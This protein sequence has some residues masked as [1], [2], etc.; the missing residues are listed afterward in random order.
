MHKS[1]IFYLLGVFSCLCICVRNMYLCKI[2]LLY[3]KPTIQV[4]I[5]QSTELILDSIY[6]I[7]IEYFFHFRS[8]L[9]HMICLSH[10]ATSAITKWES[11]KST[12][13]RTTLAPMT[14][15]WTLL[16]FRWRNFFAHRSLIIKFYAIGR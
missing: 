4:S 9:P 5:S 11:N 12:F 8:T 15:I 10:P 3:Y 13:T 14:L 1:H 2:R 6:C 7:F 16:Y